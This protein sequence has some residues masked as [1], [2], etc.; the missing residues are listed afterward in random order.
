MSDAT[1][2]KFRAQLSPMAWSARGPVSQWCSGACHSAA[3]PMTRMIPQHKAKARVCF[4]IRR[5]GV[6]TS[7][8]TEDESKVALNT[9]VSQL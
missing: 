1:C 5:F 8:L 7:K 3:L 4:L 9:F 6:A 2:A